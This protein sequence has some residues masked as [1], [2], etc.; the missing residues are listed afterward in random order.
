MSYVFSIDPR[1]GVIVARFDGVVD[2][3]QLDRIREEI[4]VH[5]D[6]RPGLDR[7]WDERDAELRLSADDLRMLADRWDNT[8]VDHGERRLGYLVKP[9]LRWG[10]NRQ[11]EAQRS[12]ADVTFGIYTSWSELLAWLG[13]PED[14]PDPVELVRRER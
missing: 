1:L 14:L 7:I 5:P 10:L 4:E 11:F 12:A 8:A 9:G 3:G 6:F 2:A 13:L